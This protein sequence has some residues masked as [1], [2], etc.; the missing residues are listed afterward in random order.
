MIQ[1]YGVH[2]NYSVGSPRPRLAGK[3]PKIGAMIV[4]AVEIA[5]GQIPTGVTY[6]NATQSIAQLSVIATMVPTVAGGATAPV[7]FSVATGS[8]PPGVALNPNT[9]S[10]GGAPMAAG[11]FTCTIT[12]SNTIGAA[13]SGTISLTVSS[14]GS[15]TSGSW[16]NN[17]IFEM[18]PAATGISANVA[19]FPVMLQLNATNSAAIFSSSSSPKD[20]RFART[21]N[22]N[23]HYPFQIE[24]WNPTLQQAVIWVLVDTLFYQ[25]SGQ[26]ITM[27]WG[28]SGASADSSGPAVFNPANGFL[29]VWHLNNNLATGNYP[30]L[31]D[32]TGN[33]YNL[34]AHGTTHVDAG[35]FDS[36]CAF[37]GAATSYLSNASVLGS[38]AV[39]TLSTW[40]ADSAALTSEQDYISLDNSPTL[41]STPN[42][43]SEVF[44]QYSGG[45]Y[46]CPAPTLSSA[47]TYTAA[48]VNPT[49]AAGDSAGEW[50]YQNGVL[51]GTANNTA[52]IIYG[53]TTPT[54]LGDNPVSGN[55]GRFLKG[56]MSEAR[57][58]NVP[59]SA[60]WILL[61]YLNQQPG[62]TFIVPISVPAVPALIAPANNAANQV[63]TP[64]LSWSTVTGAT[65]YGVEISTSSTF[66]ATVYGQTGIPSASITASGL[67]N[68]K[69]YYWQANATDLVLTSAW[70]GIWSFT[71]NATPLPGVPVLSSPTNGAT[72]QQATLSLSWST[73]PAAASYRVLVSTSSTFGSSAFGQTGLT[74]AKVA[75]S[76]IAYSQL[77]YWEAAAVNA[78]GNGNW[79][80]IWSFTTISPPPP[81]PQ[82]SSPASG[83]GGQTIPVTLIWQ[84]SPGAASYEVQVG[85]AAGFGAGSTVFDQ[86]GVTATTINVGNLQG[87][88]TYYWRVDGWNGSGPGPWSQV[89]D[90]GT[91]VTS[92]LATVD[93]ALKTDFS[94]KGKAILYSLKN[95]GHVEISFCDLLGRSALV[96]KRTQAA[97]R[98]ALSLRDCNLAA[99][100]YIVQFKAAGVEKQAVVLI[101]R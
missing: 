21:G 14:D 30:G 51:V 96:L 50:A 65:S 89:W 36:A 37:A 38:P 84:S 44:Y 4:L 9:G 91:A 100:R 45:W 58:E 62:Q 20:L 46:G 8:L 95:P 3:F 41:T 59:R 31:T 12:A 43:G 47:W 98:Y 81:A 52:P 42:G 17:Q 85:T 73:V 101:D 5:M 88:D 33:G 94:V 35:V 99:G 92:V 1:G 55:T 87:A 93:A 78:G 26:G 86:A 61:C 29:A 80:A 75:V 22:A 23:V 27:F 64:T 83:N 34:T 90:F 66:A 97:G 49:G 68:S 7:A 60:D 72:N 54:W 19:N 82:L 70:S 40:V 6:T 74:A 76:G 28:N 56:P 13:T 15:Y 32:A 39:V 18:D 48:V 57:V 71:T 10:I 25:S 79:S 69:T 16:T 11:T 24:Q 67:A 2:K 77:Y 53:A 63:L